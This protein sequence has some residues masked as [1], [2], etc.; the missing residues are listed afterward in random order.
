MPTA[1]ALRDRYTF[2]RQGAPVGDADQGAYA[3][4]LTCAAATAFLRGGEGVQAQRLQ[5]SQPVVLTIRVC[6][7]ARQITNAWRA[8]DA[9]DASRVFDVTGV[10][11]NKDDIAFLDVLAVRKVGQRG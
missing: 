2:Q 4:V 1:G 3:D 5:G 6:A 8:V 7:A 10:E 9:R 11:P